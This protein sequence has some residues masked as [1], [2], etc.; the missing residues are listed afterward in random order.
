M[1]PVTLGLILTGAS[2]ALPFIAQ[3]FGGGAKEIRPTYPWET[4]IGQR[5]FDILSQPA[6]MYTGPLT[7]PITPQEQAL[8]AALSRPLSLDLEPARSYMIRA[9]SGEYLRPE[10]QPY[11]QALTQ[12]IETARQRTLGQALDEISSAVQKA[13]IPR[14]SAE[15]NLRQ[16]AA[17]SIMQQ[18]A[19]QL[20]QLYGGI[21][22]AERQ[23]QQQL[24]PIFLQ[25]ALAPTQQAL[26]GLQA[27]QYLRQAMLQNILLPYQEWQ[28]YRQEQLLPLQAYMQMLQ[29]PATYPM[30]RPPDWYY[31]VA[32]A[33]EMLGMAG[34]YLLYPR[35]QNVP[36]EV[37]V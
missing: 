35:R 25:Y 14:G 29:I 7:V 11:L 33:S 36:K 4:P 1:D 17:E 5:I 18:T 3:A 27:Q 28:R 15:A 23:R 10:R 2:I 31:Y 6:Q 21:Y 22:E 12:A 30:Y 24:L 8:V 13:G 20:A 9:L 34:G 37:E 32:P 19:G 16:R 26:A